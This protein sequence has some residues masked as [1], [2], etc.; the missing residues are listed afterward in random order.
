MSG[1]VLGHV[2]GNA[3]AYLALFV[4]LGGTAY[5]ASEIGKN[6]VGSRQIKNGQVK[7]KD[8]AKNSVDDSK[9]KNG[10]L[11]SDDFAPGQLP[12]GPPGQDGLD[13]QDATNMFAWIRADGDLRFGSGV[14]SAKNVTPTNPKYEVM[15][16]RSLT[17]CALL[18]NAGVGTP[19]GPTPLTFNGSGAPSVTVSD[20]KPMLARVNFRDTDTGTSVETAFFIA[21]FC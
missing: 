7:A 13:G 18:A 5:S 17:G 15:F 16:E 1:R 11:L 12:Q 19:T 2:R 4:A 3:I 6:D 10:S 8:L 9:V 21:A 14:T 20:D